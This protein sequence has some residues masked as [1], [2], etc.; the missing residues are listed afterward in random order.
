MNQLNNINSN[1]GNKSR[2]IVLNPMNS[3][4]K[5]QDL[6]CFSHLRWNLVF[7]RPQHLLTR[8]AKEIR[9]FYFEEPVFE[10]DISSYLQ[11]EINK[12]HPNVYILTPHFR[13]GLKEIQINALLH[14]YVDSFIRL[15]RVTDYII[16][17]LTPMALPFSHHLT[18]KTVVYDCMDEL[19]GFK[20]AHPLMLQHENMLMKFADTVFTGGQSLYE[21][22]KSRHFNIHP[23]PSSIDKEHFESGL[24]K[25][26]P[27][28][29]AGIPHPRVGFYG[30]IDERMD[31]QLLDG[32]A[33]AMK[34]FNFIII[35]PV[36]KIDPEDLPQH[37]NIHYLGGKKYEELPAYLAHWDVAFLPFAKNESTR[38][39]S[40]T[41]TPEYLCAG[42][43]VVSTSIH[44]VIDPYGISGLVQIAD[45]VED[46]ARAIKYALEQRNDPEWIRKRKEFLGKNSWDLTYARMKKIIFDSIEKKETLNGK[47]HRI[48][49]QPLTNG[50]EV[51]TDVKIRIR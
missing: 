35:G 23:F 44:D 14:D 1:E 49:N 28:D 27:T 38:F 37:N 41:K 42:K 43:P 33:R 24:K 10:N 31:I 25:A 7:Q 8:W 26:D 3:L 22:K 21:Q 50:D 4:N 16:W 18:A 17:Y 13:H 45:T 11:I 40:P 5:V 29:Q 2:E 9:V 30:V 39:I 32:L 36:V 19:S 20:G 34:D 47:E 15:H 48:P 46:S 51:N 12:E 6:I